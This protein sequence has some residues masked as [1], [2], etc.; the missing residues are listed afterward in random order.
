MRLAAVDT[1]LE[2][3]KEIEE[4]VGIRPEECIQMTVS[5]NT[6]MV[7]FLLGLDAFCVFAAPYAV[8]ADQPGFLKG[9]EIGIPV[10][11]YVFCYPGK[12]NYL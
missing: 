5:G 9:I 1:I 4:T 11:G 3:L 12:S 7:H 8:W 2:N 10:N 6:T